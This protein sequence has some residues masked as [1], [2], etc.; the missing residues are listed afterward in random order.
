M[1]HTRASQSLVRL[2]TVLNLLHAHPG[3]LRMDYLAEQVGVPEALLR[4]EI[5]DFY[6]ADTLGVRPDTIIFM[7]AEGKEDDPASAEMVRVV[8]DTPGAELGV[9][10]QTPQKWLEV[11]QTAS[12]MSEMRPDDTDLA[13]AVQV[14]AQRIL[15]GV[16]QRPD[17]EIGRVLSEAISKRVA[18]EIEYS[19]TWKPGLVDRTVHPLRLVETARGWELD[20]LLPDD[21]VR[22][23]IIDRISDV[24]LTQDSFE[25][26]RG[27]TAR[28]VEHRRPTT[29][30][31]VVPLG[32]QW[33]VDRYAETSTVVEQDEGDVSIS[34][35]FLPPVAERVGLVLITA[36]NSFVIRPDHLKSAGQEMADVLLVH[37][38]LQG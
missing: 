9:E 14:I 18:V 33:A 34:A 38:G 11:Y 16:P 28:L 2:S 12:R 17:S 6:T 5:L 32:Y 4:R 24:T 27:T 25:V 21:E 30:D 13:E 26:P 1:K 7:S 22:T 29:V 15:T 37:H 8:T 10:L 36:P 23:F 3:G 35:Q 20:A 31:L 19:R